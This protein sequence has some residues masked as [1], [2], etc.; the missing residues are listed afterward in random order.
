M[1]IGNRCILAKKS[2]RFIWAFYK[3][4]ERITQAK[5]YPYTVKKSRFLKEFILLRSRDF[6]LF[7]L[8]SA[9]TITLKRLVVEKMP[10]KSVSPFAVA[11]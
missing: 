10:I 3:L 4:E 8:E 1:I 9:K 5:Q 6:D 11:S 7:Q 2:Q